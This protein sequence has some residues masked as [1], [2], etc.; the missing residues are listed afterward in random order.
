MD[1]GYVRLEHANPESKQWFVVNWCL[2]NTCNFSC[3]YCPKA[4][5]DGSN[6]WHDKHMVKNF[7]T[8]VRNHH[9]DK[10]IYFEFTGGEVTL[11]K[12]FTEICQYCTDLGI[13]VGMI[14]N[15]SRTIRWWTQNKGFFDHVCLSLHPEFTKEDHFTEVIRLLHVDTRV[16]VNIMMSPERFDHC[17]EV[18]H[19]IKGIGN[20][21]M[22]LQ[23]LIQD[24]GSELYDYTEQ[25]RDVLARQYELLVKHIRHDR[26]FPYYRGA[27]R[28]VF[29]DGRTTVQPAHRFISDGSNDWS[30]WRCYAGVE[31]LIVEMDGTIRRGWCK[32]GGP[33]GH[34]ESLSLDLP[35][36]PVICDKTMCHCNYDIM[37]TKESPDA[38]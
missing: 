9:W 6:R 15:G 31:Q 27:M 20:I 22:A 38:G 34:I 26:A 37:S 7:I 11:Y 16:H 5:H 1:H 36:S 17:L 10:N 18:A 19:R 33:V 3:S 25:Q 21:S 13:K 35:T 23:P 8:K 12:D 28:K 24:F 30:G 14:S 32:V 4:L 29:P 2:G